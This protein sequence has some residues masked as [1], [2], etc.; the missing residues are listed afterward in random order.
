MQCCWWCAAGQGW[1]MSACP[2]LL[3]LPKIVELRGQD[4]R[5]R[6]LAHHAEVRRLRV[7]HDSSSSLAAPPR[8][9]HCLAC[10][11]TTR[12]RPAAVCPRLAD[13]SDSW[14]QDAS[15]SFS[16]CPSRSS[17]G[18]RSKRRWQFATGRGRL[19]ART[20][21]PPHSRYP[22]AAPL[23]PATFATPSAQCFFSPRRRAAAG[24]AGGQQ[25]A[26]PRATVPSFLP[27][28]EPGQPRRAM[29]TARAGELIYEYVL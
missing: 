1:V 4:P 6:R 27:F 22:P 25:A 5:R 29:R 7:R 24:Y 14:A 16:P 9:R 19:Q 26:A 2:V 23:A 3:C 10:R 13:R 28:G 21:S 20:T 8:R 18:V 15:P 17:T 12:P 11:A